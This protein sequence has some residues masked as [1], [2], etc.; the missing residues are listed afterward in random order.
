MS[1]ATRAHVTAD[2]RKSILGWH[3]DLFRSLAG[4]PVALRLN[5]EPEQFQDRK[6]YADAIRNGEPGPPIRISFPTFTF[7]TLMTSALSDA[8]PN[9]ATGSFEPVPGRTSSTPCVGD[10]RELPPRWSWRS[11][12]LLLPRSFLPT[13]LSKTGHSK[14]ADIPMT[15]SEVGSSTRGFPPYFTRS[16]TKCRVPATSNRVNH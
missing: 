14:P 6:A 3:L 15:R 5:T 12:A 4:T 13:I 11:P 7:G 2:L 8:A 10:Y 16:R 9:A 1:D